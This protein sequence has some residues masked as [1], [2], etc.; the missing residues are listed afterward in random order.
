MIG[1]PSQESPGRVFLRGPDRAGGLASATCR[2]W[3]AGWRDLGPALGWF[4]VPQGNELKIR[5]DRALWSEDLA[6]IEL[7]C[8]QVLALGRSAPWAVLPFLRGL[9]A[10]RALELWTVPVGDDVVWGIA[11][12]AGLG[13]LNL[14]GTQISDTGLAVLARMP[15]LRSLAVPGRR[16]GDPAME[17]LAGC[18]RLADLDLSGSSVT[19]WGLA[20]LS[21]APRLRRLTLWQA[22]ITDAGLACLASLPHLTD[23]DLGATSI[24]DRGLVF[25]TRLRGLRRLSLADTSVTREGLRRLRA[26]L[27]TCR[28]EPPDV[29]AG[30]SG[31]LHQLA[32]RAD[33]AAPRRPAGSSLLR[34][35]AIAGPPEPG[36]TPA[37]GPAAGS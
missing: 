25:L 22:P 28:I 15:S 30:C 37:G 31:P 29:V 8:P 17:A 26:E 23:L 10:L 34:R 21:A 32:G 11:E 7:A 27:P 19:D 36:A 3:Q 12:C 18:P 24:S 1:F 2:S 16:T 5:V 13:A 6:C 14:W 20:A 9:P 33:R 35:G 4:E